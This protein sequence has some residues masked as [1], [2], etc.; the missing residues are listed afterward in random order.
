MRCSIILERKGAWEAGWGR[1]RV[2]LVKSLITRDRKRCSWGAVARFELKM[3]ADIKCIASKATWH[4]AI[5]LTIVCYLYPLSLMYDS[6]ML[7]LLLLPSKAVN[8]RNPKNTEHIHPFS[9]LTTN[10]FFQKSDVL[11]MAKI[12]VWYLRNITNY[13]NV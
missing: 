12:Y 4:H 6:I 5:K 3:S 11:V 10:S 2:V 8:D 7:L 13:P 9:C 1:E